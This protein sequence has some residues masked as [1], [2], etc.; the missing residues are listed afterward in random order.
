MSTLYT[1]L[2]KSDITNYK[3]VCSSSYLCPRHDLKQPR[4]VEPAQKGN[5]DERGDGGEVAGVKEGE[6]NAQKTSSEAHVD[7]HD[8]TEKRTDGPCLPGSLTHGWLA[9]R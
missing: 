9:S 6:R 3:V 4:A 7:H 2:S 5:E 1:T 8:V